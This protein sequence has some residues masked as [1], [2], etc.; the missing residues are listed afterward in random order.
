[1]RLDKTKEFWVRKA[2]DEEGHS[3]G[4]GAPLSI[5][6]FGTPFASL[7]THEEALEQLRRYNVAIHTGVRPKQVLSERK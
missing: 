5:E 4:A 3:V 7:L 6:D 2:R 1:M